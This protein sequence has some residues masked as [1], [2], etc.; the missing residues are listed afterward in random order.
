MRS[1]YFK[2]AGSSTGALLLFWLTGFLS[3]CHLIRTT[4]WILGPGQEHFNYHTVI[5]KQELFS[6]AVILYQSTLNLTQPSTTQQSDHFKAPTS[7][8]KLCR[9]ESSN[10]NP[11]PAT[12]AAAGSIMRLEPATCH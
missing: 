7:P 4:F 1:A 11:T 8:I 6:F 2:L 9:I 10:R 5:V 12:P 3:M